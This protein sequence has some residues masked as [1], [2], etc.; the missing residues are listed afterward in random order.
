MREERVDGRVAVVAARQGGVIGAGQ[1]RACG[2]E[3]NAISLRVRRGT[4]HRI[5]RG[6]Y[7]VGHRRLDALGRW[8]GA[9]LA[10]GDDAVL[11]HRSAGLAWGLVESAG[12]TIDVTVPRAGGRR[13][14]EGVRVHR[15]PGLL[16]ADRTITLDVLPITTP[17][18]TLADI[19]PVVAQH[20]LERAVERAEEMRVVDH[21]RLRALTGTGRPGVRA[22]RAA[23][24]M[25]VTMTRSEL[26]R[27]FLALC[28]SHGVPRPRVNHPLG[29]YRVDFHWPRQRLVVETD[30]GEHHYTRTA[31]ES[32]RR[33]DA[34][35]ALL[36]YRVVRFTHRRVRDEPAEVARILRLL[37]A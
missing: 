5:H 1:L 31:F 23:L 37:L 13:Q 19:A 6:V 29:D 4:L 9:V 17:E 34:D 20:V 15:V 18:R 21:D 35:L 33:R 8:M 24:A 27:R 11:S 30:G 12:A 32:D 36:G 7:A 16:D 26:E 25:P 28:R 14:H 3:R 2:L 10:C 22:L